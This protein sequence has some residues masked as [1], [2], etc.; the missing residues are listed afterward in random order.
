MI[1]AFQPIPTQTKLT[2]YNGTPILQHGVCSI[3]CSYGGKEANASF[4]VA[5]VNGP[6]ICC[7]PTVLGTSISGTGT[8]LRKALTSS[9]LLHTRHLLEHQAVHLPWV[10]LTH[11]DPDKET[12]IQVDASLQGL[13]SALV[14]EG[15]VITFAS[16]ALTDTE[17]CYANIEREMLLLLL[18][19]NFTP[20]YLA[21]NSQW[22]RI[23]RNFELIH[24]KNLTA[25]HPRLQRMLL[26][27]Q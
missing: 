1:I 9:G 19:R 25:A 4:Y 8:S 7:L 5:D 10:S 16:R 20:T 2:A 17:A 11:F 15:K 14:Q 26:R 12:V 18:A 22:S 13:G 21:R 23:T 3:K 27:I 6:A 24:L